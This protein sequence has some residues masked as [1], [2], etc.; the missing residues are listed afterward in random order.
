MKREGER[1]GGVRG[2]KEGKDTRT[3]GEEKERREEASTCHPGNI[4]NI[5]VVM[6]TTDLVE[7]V[8]ECDWVLSEEMLRC[9]WEDTNLQK[10]PET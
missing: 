9:L 3:G 10:K 4:T 8:L 6:V 1:E 5:H 2:S 7:E